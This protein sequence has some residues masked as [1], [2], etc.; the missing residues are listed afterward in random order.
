MPE[1]EALPLLL[2]VFPG[3]ESRRPV[4]MELQR[5]ARIGMLVSTDQLR[6]SAWAREMVSADCWIET[7][8]VGHGETWE[9]VSEWSERTGNKPAGVMCYDEFG[10]ELAAMLCE[11]LGVPGTPLETVRAVR[12]KHAFRQRCLEH[13]IRAPR[14]ALLCSEEDLEDFIREDRFNFPCVIKPCKGA[15]SWH[16]RRVESLT[17]L[18]ECWHQLSKDLNG[19]CFPND[20]QTAGFLCEEY[21]GGTEVDVDGWAQNGEP[22][23]MQV[24]D[25]NPAIEPYF[26][27]VGGVYP[28]QLP[29]TSI[30]AIRQLTSDVLKAFPGVHGCFHFEAK[31]DGSVAYPIELNLRTGGAECPASVAAVSGY[32]LPEVAARLALNQM[33]VIRETVVQH[34]CVASANIHIDS[35]GVIA[36]C[37]DNDLD[38]VG[39]KVVTCVL[40][41]DSVGKMHKPNNGSQSCLGWIAA[42]GR[43]LQEAQSNLKAAEAQLRIGVVQSIPSIAFD[44]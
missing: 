32:Y 15:G 29:E 44:L 18:R 31:V 6:H 8:G 34:N 40:L 5:S 3:R 26:L 1:S 41:K 27:E 36:E 33:P 17:D 7:P 4:L 22:A 14:H 16:I 9:A 23:F 28:S 20:V 25:N 12:S 42:G 10:V 21:I 35:E 30:A 13:G 39:N 43:D 11:R 37:D 38:W 19:S 2:V 24:A